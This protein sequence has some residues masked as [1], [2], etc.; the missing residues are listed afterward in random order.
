VSL[1]QTY[2]RLSKS[3]GPGE[4]PE[5]IA[6]HVTL[7]KGERSQLAELATQIL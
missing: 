6:G 5:T 4:K 7:T 2:F 1:Y 3:G